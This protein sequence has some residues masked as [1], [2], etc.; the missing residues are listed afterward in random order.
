MNESKSCKV[1]V[2]LKEKEFL[3]TTR[4]ETFTVFIFVLLC[5]ELVSF[6]FEFTISEKLYE[7]KKRK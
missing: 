2:V 3:F 5:L 4:N 6:V 7:N 1:G